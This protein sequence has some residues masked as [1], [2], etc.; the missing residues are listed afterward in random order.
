[1]REMQVLKLWEQAVGRDRW[2]REEALLNTGQPSP[3]RLGARNLA[4]LATRNELFGCAWPPRSTF[5]A[6]NTECE[7]AVDSVRLTDELASQQGGDTAAFDWAGQRVIARPL[8]VDD[9][10]AALPQ[11]DAGSA[12]RA[13]LQRCLSIDRDLD[14]IDEDA[15]EELNRHLEQLDPASL[16]AFALQCPACSHAWSA[17]VDIGEAL[18]AEVRHAAERSL[19]EIDTLA[20]SYGWTEETV[21]RLSPLR[22]AAYMQLIAGA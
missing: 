18:W 16:V 10:V 15:V 1:M 13:L 21:M 3:R 19:I 9:L 8:T 7:F 5:P 14:E 20:R 22:R 17:A 11:P 4:L 2:Q 6:C 12:T